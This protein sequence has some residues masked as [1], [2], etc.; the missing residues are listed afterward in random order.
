MMRFPGN[1]FRFVCTFEEPHGIS[2]P[3]VSQS[4]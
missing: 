2:E 3:D 4:L 1:P